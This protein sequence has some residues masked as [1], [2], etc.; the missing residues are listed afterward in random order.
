MYNET[1]GIVGAETCGTLTEKRFKGIKPESEYGYGY[2]IQGKK[3]IKY[4]LFFESAVDLLSF[5]EIE[6]LKNKPIA[7]TLLVSMA[8]IKS[9]VIEHTLN[10]RNEPLQPVLCVDN[11]NAGADF[12]KRVRAQI[13]GIKTFLPDTQYK[14]WNEQ[15]KAM[16]KH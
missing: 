16:K 5:I 6:R 4:A 8:G 12:I 7:D 3:E 2:S 10:R 1:G 11:D 14:D 15:L 13:K 9:N